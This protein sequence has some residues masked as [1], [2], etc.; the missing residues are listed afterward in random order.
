M[1]Y[2]GK[3]CQI[4][5][6]CGSNNI[7]CNRTILKIFKS[8]VARILIRIHQKYVKTANLKVKYKNY[9]KLIQ[10]CNYICSDIK[11]KKSGLPDFLVFIFF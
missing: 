6:R 1:V 4:L 2:I 5:Q 7:K 3:S 9:S 10:I 8:R 11:S